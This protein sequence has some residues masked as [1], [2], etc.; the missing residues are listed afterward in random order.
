MDYLVFLKE[1]VAPSKVS[2]KEVI[3]SKLDPKLK[4]DFRRLWDESV[5]DDNKHSIKYKDKPFKP[6]TSYFNWVNRQRVLVYIK[7]DSL[8][9][10]IMLDRSNRKNGIIFIHSFIVDPKQRSRGVGTA[11]M[12]KAFQIAKKDGFEKVDLDVWESNKKAQALYSKH[13]F[14]KINVTMRK[15]V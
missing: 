1:A 10:F 6:K 15:F 9:G 8:L 7:G 11:M 3:P 5:K 14:K 2:I 4:D 13:G 12:H